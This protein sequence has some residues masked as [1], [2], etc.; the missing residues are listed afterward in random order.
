MSESDRLAEA[1]EGSIAVIGMACRFPGARSIEEFWDNLCKGVESI[2]PLTD[3]ERKELDPSLR[4]D[5]D[6]VPVFSCVEDF[7]LFDAGLFGM[8]PREAALTDPQQRL[9]LLCS[10]EALEDAGYDSTRVGWPVGVFAAS[11]RSDYG[12]LLEV[13]QP[14]ID[15]F[16]ISLNC[17][18]DYLATRVAH[19]LDL[20]G[21]A[22]TVQ[23]ACSSSLVAVHLA[24][25][26]LL[27][28]ECDMALAGASSLRFTEK[29]YLYKE[30]SVLS[31]DGHCRAFDAA[32][33]GTVGGNG[34][35]VVVLK[36]LADALKDG[37]S[38]RAVIRGSAMNNDGSA[39]AS[40]TAPTVDGQVAAITDAL[41]LADVPSESVTFV[42]AHG[43]GTFIGDPIEVAALVRAYPGDTPALLGSAKTNVGH[44]NQA[45]GMV[46]LIKAA[47]AVERGVIPP[48]L[49]FQSPNPNIQW[50]RFQVNAE[51]A[52]F[53]SKVGPRRAG[54]NALGV[55]GTNVHLVLE[56]PPAPAA[57]VG[58]ARFRLL[59]LSARSSAAVQQSAHALAA[60]LKKGT[61]AHLDDVAFTLQQG[62]RAF[63]WRTFAV[64]RSTSG[65]AAALEGA[66]MP[67]V[68]ASVSALPVVFM[69]PGA[70]TQYPAMGGGLYASEPVY[71]EAFDQCA[72]LLQ[73]II[74]VDL[75]ALLYGPPGDASEADGLLRMAIQQPAIVACE[76]A[77]AQLW[78]HWG[79]QPAAMIGHSTGEY[80]A[81]CLSGVMSLEVTLRLVAVR[82]EL[83]QRSEAGSM[84]VVHLPE[85]ELLSALPDAV[86]LAA[87]DTPARCVV[88]GASA[89]VEALLTSLEA[90]G[91]RVQ[92]LKVERAGHSALLD[93]MGESF[94]REFEGV[95]LRPPSIPYVSNVTGQWITPEEATSVAYYLRHLRRPVRFADGL[96]TLSSSGPALYLEVGPGG[97]LSAIGPQVLPSPTP[98]VAS[99]RHPKDPTDDVELLLGALGRLWSLGSEVDF[100]KASSVPV[101]RRTALPTYPFELDRHW[102]P[103]DS[104]SAPGTFRSSRPEGAAAPEGRD[105]VLAQVKSIWQTALGKDAIGDQDPFMSLGGNSLTA[106][107]VVAEL[108]DAFGIS[109]PIHTFYANPTVADI[110]D[111]L[112]RSAK[113]RTGQ[114]PRSQRISALVPLREG[115]SAEPVFLVHAIGGGVMG[116]RALVDSG[117]HD[118]QVW[119]LQSLEDEVAS[120][121]SSIEGLAEYYSSSIADLCPRGRCILVGHS[122]GGVVA[123]EMARRLQAR[124]LIVPLVGMIDSPEPGKNFRTDEDAELWAAPFLLG[125]P[126]PAFR[127][128]LRALTPPQRRPF[129][130]SQLEKATG[131][132]LA[133]EAVLG[134][135]AVKRFLRYMGALESYLPGA[136][137]GRISYFRA[138]ER[139]EGTAPGAISWLERATEGAELVTVPGNHFSMLDSPHVENLGQ[140]LRRS[141]SAALLHSSGGRHR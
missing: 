130:E 50:G 44:L 136:F 11:D 107:G 105:A 29:G 16:T 138:H 38:I 80:T 62:R 46:G 121:H 34:A 56:Q 93:R 6:F 25:Q 9:F 132:S 79:I 116:Y 71:R 47:L 70:G 42:E 64:A 87:V 109:L 72:A 112:V 20:K 139:P 102:I 127:E 17:D 63:P 74:G 78:R 23:T 32:A 52:E 94:A 35:A 113:P 24:C 26:N 134:S 91:V 115:A 45:A 7:Q 125:N 48:T 133:F 96:K 120:N 140:R 13:H 106:I 36:R 55:G 8:T 92:R 57:P 51:R 68:Q 14:R 114:S 101:G 124:G 49:H 3:D 19:R 119:G 141:L 97:G 81:A 99:M 12:R 65:A 128:Q 86:S 66:A 39:K 37:D 33:K 137:A 15:R 84:A 41:R 2:R 60:S 89:D 67:A 110:A 117:L 58:E 27:A 4:D 131:S 85:S 100:A 129:L 73:P 77:L 10:H 95:T 28:G 111:A 30:G 108:K 1:Q 43:T 123:F 75:R 5:P 104:E 98:F 82:A 122:F 61:G 31:P 21:P 76:Y 118:R 59:P 90:A 69:F 18:A 53:T 126:D 83:M 135:R 88:S 22:L 103:Q 54:V 40:F